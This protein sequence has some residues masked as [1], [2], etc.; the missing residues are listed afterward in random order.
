MANQTL[1]ANSNLDSAAILGLNN[2]E[3]ITLAGFSLTWDSDN[4]W[5][6]QAAV[7]GNLVYSA[8]IGGSVTIDGRNVWWIPYTGGTGTVPALGTVGTQNSTG[9]TSGATGEFL[10]IWASI[11]GAP[12]AAAAAVPAAGFIKFRSKVG[13]FT[14]GETITLSNG[15]TLVVNSTTGGQRGWL[16]IVAES[17]NN[18]SV[19]RLGSTSVLGDWYELGVT[20]GTDD[21]VFNSPVLDTIPAIWVETSAGSGVYE[22]WLNGGV[23][24]GTATAYIATDVRGK[25]FGQWKEV[26]AN[27]TISTN[28]VTMTDT[29]G[30]VVGMPIQDT[31]STTVATLQDGSCIT[32]ITPGVSV[33]ISKTAS[34]TAAITF[35]SPLAT[36]T[37]AR[38]AS[39][40]C[41]YKPPTGCKVR[42]PNVILSQAG[43]GSFSGNQLHVGNSSRYEL[44]GT[45]AGAFTFDK[46]ICNW[47]LNVSGAYSFSMTNCAH[48]APQLVSMA[49]FATPFTYTENGSG[50]EGGIGNT[51]VSLANSPYG[52]TISNNRACRGNNAGTS[53]VV[54]SISDS[55]NLTFSGNQWETFGNI[56]STERQTTDTRN[57]SLTRI[58]TFSITNETLI[59]GS[60]F[61]SPGSSGTLTNIVYADRLIGTTSTT[62]AIEPIRLTSG[63]DSITISGLS[64]F[65][66]ISDVNPYSY[67]VALGGSSTRIKVR[68]I[69]SAASPLNT[70][71]VNVSAG[72]VT[73][74]VTLNSELNRIYLTGARTAVIQGANTSSG[75]IADNIW[76][77]TSSATYL[78]SLNST[79]RGFRGTSGTTGQS[80]VYGSH[81]MDQFISTT[82]GRLIICCNEPTSVT[83]SQAVV[84]SGTPKYTST[85]SVSMPSLGDQ[86]IWEMPYFL[87]GHT[88][89]AA[90][91]PTVTGTLPANITLEF[92]WN[93]GSGY[94]GSWLAAT[95]GNLSGVGSWSAATGIKIKVRA[96]TA[97]GDPTNALTFIR[98]DTVTDATSQQTEYP[99]QYTGTGTMPSFAAGSRVQIYNVTTATEIYNAIPSGTSLVYQYYT[100]TGI[101]SG[102]TVRVRI[103][104]PGYLPFEGSAVAGA[105]G[106]GV[107]GSQSVDSVYV[108]N[109]VDG[110]TVTEFTADYPNIQVDI[111]DPDNTTSIQRLY[112]WAKYNDATSVGIEQFFA[113]VVADNSLSYTIHNAIADIYLDNVKTDGCRITGGW[114]Y[115]DDGAI[116]VSLTSTG[117]IYFESGIKLSASNANP[118]TNISQNGRSYGA[119][120]RDMYAVLVGAT[121]GG[122]TTAEVFKDPAGST[123][124]T[125]NNNGVDRTSV[126]VAGS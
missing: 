59:G 72:A 12:V 14:N 29:T 104:S 53:P 77:G 101:S 124:V 46:V 118:W 87:L 100:G 126:V 47:F 93:T 106:F 98:F 84:T 74:S 30:F 86:I 42:I 115:R 56:G 120:H 5:S 27:A 70:G 19:P 15:A 76:G 109:G 108:G 68:N 90:T 37:I 26:A 95:S 32:A 112:A 61:L 92:Q 111:N 39:N 38:R 33:T 75:I 96:T 43:S 78:N 58:S 2:G 67:L 97:T 52:G 88:G 113:S 21:Q 79:H 63:S 7:V 44:Q 81:W 122:G 24:W 119:Q 107:L 64:W 105:A 73:H 121:S 50:L 8:T 11:P 41:G 85:G 36:I 103:A 83:S 102:D 89:F 123:R 80:S 25:F 66:G 51:I 6:Q 20:D 1:T 71:S 4:R 35:R 40:S 10:G 54:C 99:Y 94:N 45:N 82:V 13:T 116:P 28:T 23:R 117:P 3:D 55:A 34:A 69:G 18:V 48:G 16:H 91:D 57:L 22:K 9:G 110:S 31:D 62:A 49:N 114:L 125:S 60:I 65:G 17:G